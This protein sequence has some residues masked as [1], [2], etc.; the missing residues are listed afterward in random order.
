MNKD[1][2]FDFDQ[3]SSAH[4]TDLDC[5]N[6]FCFDISAMLGACGYEAS[7]LVGNVH[8]SSS[9]NPSRLVNAVLPLHT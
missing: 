6:G 7:A 8:R 2:I 1:F 5:R 4:M 9:L 3:T